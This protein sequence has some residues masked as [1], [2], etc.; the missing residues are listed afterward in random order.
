[1]KRL[2]NCFHCL[3]IT[4]TF[5]ALNFTLSAQPNQKTDS[6]KKALKR[7]NKTDTNYI[8]TLNQLAYRTFIKNPEKTVEYA[9]ES[10][11][12]AKEIKY[13]KGEAGG[14]Q[15][16]AIGHAILGKFSEAKIHFLKAAQLF[17]QIKDDEGL[18]GAYNGLGNV[19]AELSQLDESIKYLNKSLNLFEKLG[20]KNRVALLYNNIA[21]TYDDLKNKDKAIEYYEKSLKKYQEIGDEGEIARVYQ[22]LNIMFFDKKQYDKAKA[23]AQKALNLWKKLED[24]GEMSMTYNS[25][26]LIY[27]KEKQYTKAIDYHKKAFELASK[28]KRKSSTAYSLKHLGRAYQK[29]KNYDEA[30]NYFQRAL[31][32]SKEIKQRSLS[33]DVYKSLFRV[34]SLRGNYQKALGYLMKSY[35]LERS[36]FNEK[37]TKEAA[38]LATKYETERK[39]REL[40][41]QQLT[42]KNNE[43][44]LRQRNTQILALTG[45][46]ILLLLFAFSLFRSR[47]KQFKLN[48]LLSD[49]KEEIEQQA[50]ELK[51]TN[52][53]L[54][55]LDAF[56]QQMM[57]MIVHDLKNPLNSIIGLSKVGLTDKNL[58]HYQVINQDGV[59]MQ[60]LVMN[61][62][63]VHKFEDNQLQIK[64]LVVELSDLVALAT[65]Q[66]ELLAQNKGVTLQ[67]DNLTTSPLKVDPELIVR[68]LVNLL[69]NAI[70]YTPQGGNIEVVSTAKTQQGKEYL[71]VSVKDNGVG[72]APEFLDSIFNKYQQ[73]DK[74][75]SGMMRS[76][77][78]G[79]TFCKI[80]I[81]THDGKIGVDSTQG[82]GATFWFTLPLAS[83][84]DGLATKITE[85]NDN[86]IQLNSAAKA[87]LAPI[88]EKIE[89]YE[90]YE[91]SKITQVLSE[92]DTE[93]NEHLET[94]KMAIE[95]AVYSHNQEALTKLLALGSK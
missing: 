77:G 14:E 37:Q 17:E 86:Q 88:I 95:D 60:H 38:R 87:L 92:L 46:G 30:E 31:A 78:L 62:L 40:A 81:D 8:K 68:V 47:R 74:K 52:N 55:K 29:N 90:I 53:Q 45:V 69:T 27:Q 44:T 51:A 15:V 39:D 25:L 2:G 34:D 1:M 32:I 71:K 50:E 23:Y 57:S 5:T 54:V 48:L 21:S 79:L 33:K 4:C 72:I 85:S 94:W 19:T 13:L 3:I 75:K 10:I 91:A 76:T 43:L 24:E 18:A 12:L 6:L 35:A 22:N 16:F 73:V 83:K 7:F 93:S 20:Q 84:D 42:I 80:V 59:R 66:I 70:K 67:A 9:R 56:K 11:Q 63:D 49:Q 89:Q 61:I 26:G 65:Q 82:Q 28:L 41:Q 64:P 58:E 36:I